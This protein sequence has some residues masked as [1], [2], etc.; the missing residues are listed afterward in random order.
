MFDNDDSFISQ[1]NIPPEWPET[2]LQVVTIKLTNWTLA[3]QKK[4]AKGGQVLIWIITE[5]GRPAELP[6]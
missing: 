6:Q 5:F 3:M 4:T 2:D 1:A